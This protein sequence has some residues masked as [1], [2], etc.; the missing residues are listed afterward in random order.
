MYIVLPLLHFIYRLGR[1]KLYP[2][3]KNFYHFHGNAKIIDVSRRGQH[4]KTTQ[5]E[6]L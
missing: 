2:K 5:E 6:K 3:N 1:R 4:E